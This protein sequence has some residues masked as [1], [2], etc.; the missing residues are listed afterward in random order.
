MSPSMVISEP[1]TLIAS[2]SWQ[3]SV[4][5]RSTLRQRSKL[6]VSKTCEDFLRTPGQVSTL[7]AAP[8]LFNHLSETHLALSQT[9]YWRPNIMI[10]RKL[11][12]LILQHRLLRQNR[13][14]RR[15]RTNV[16]CWATRT[17]RPPRWPV[18]AM[19]SCTSILQTVR[20]D[21]L[22]CSPP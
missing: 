21:S 8:Q 7:V 5:M 3:L 12:A 6:S 13:C 16:P 9:D 19:V 10:L 17:T 15:D 18:V 14:L 4:R 1:V 11:K 22:R 2:P 20:G